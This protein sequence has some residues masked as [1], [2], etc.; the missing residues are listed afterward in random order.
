VSRLLV[1]Y[2]RS[3]QVPWALPGAVAAVAGLTLLGN[4]AD[5]PVDALVFA[6]LGLAIGLGVLGYGLGGASAVLEQGAAIRWPSWRV[7]HV[8]AIS[9]VV[10]LAGFA[11]TAAPAEL[12]VR[13]AAGLAGLTALA[14]VAFGNQLAWVLPV[15]WAGVSAAVPPMADPVILRVLT[16]PTQPPDS[17]SATL[18]ALVLAGTG[19]VAYAARGS[20]P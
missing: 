5:H 15:G 9:A 13:D 14:A 18:T 19:L 1:L 6:V 4:D 10:V 7:A 3:R 11:T 12:V 8:V 20:R 17:G 2:L 16:W